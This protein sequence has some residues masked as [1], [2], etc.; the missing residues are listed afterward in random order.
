MNPFEHSSLA[1]ILGNAKVLSELASS[2]DAQALVSMLTKT[3]DK[4][5]LEQMAQNAVKGDMG[6]M[7]E[8]IRSVVQ[9]PQGQELLRRLS[10]S[11]QKE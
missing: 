8:L 2:P 7:Q 5:G 1:E 9:D 3:H 6:T 10:E 4:E 11:F